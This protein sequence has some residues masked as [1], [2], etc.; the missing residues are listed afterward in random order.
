MQYIR[1]PSSIGVALLSLVLAGFLVACGGGQSTDAMLA[2]A[3][4]YLAKNDYKAAAIQAKNVLQKDANSAEG[5]YLL[6]VALLGSGDGAGAEAEL[7]KALSFDYPKDKVALPLAR[8][9]LA[10]RQFKQLVDEYG[11]VQLPSTADQAALQTALATAYTARGEPAQARDALKAALAA[12]PTNAPALLAQAREKASAKD[13]D[14]ALASIESILVKSPG[15][16]EAWTLKGDVLRIGKRQLDEALAAYRKAMETK[17]DFQAAHVG[18]IQVLLAQAKVDDASTQLAA[19]KKVAPDTYQTRYLDTLIAYLRKEA[20]RALELSQQLTRMAPNNLRAL[21]L[22][23]AVELKFGSPVQ[24]ELHL[25]KVLKAAPQATV[26]RR[27]LVSTYLRSRQGAKALEALQPLLKGDAIDAETNAL[28]GQV[29]LQ[30]GDAKKAQ[31]FLALAAKQDP[32]N[33]NARANLALAHLAD[34]RD[35]LGFAELQQMSDSETAVTADV[36]LI[37]EYLRRGEFDKAL[38]AVDVIEKKQP[39]KPTAHNLRGRVLLA[40]KDQAGARASFERALALDATHL[41]SALALSAMD[42]DQKKPDQA[43]KWLDA[44]LAKDPK[45]TRALVLLAELRSRSGAKP[46]E[47]VDLFRKAIASNPADKAPQLMLVEYLLGNNDAKQAVAAAQTAA[48][49]ISDSP[50]I[51]DALGRAQQASGDMNQALVTYAKVATL[52]PLSPQ[53]L[54]RLANAQV[55]A[56]DKDGALAS[57][58]KALVIQPDMLEAQRRLMVLHLDSGNLK[59]ALVVAATVQQQRPKEAVGYLL[60]GDAASKQKNWDMAAEAYRRGLKQV[61]APELA[62]QLHTALGRADKVAERDKFAAAWLKDNPKDPLFR[63]YLADLALAKQDYALAEKVYLG[64]LQFQPANVVALNNLAWVTGKL[65][66]DGAIAYA[67]KAVAL[68]PNQAAFLD[69]LAML[70]SDKN[71]YARALE[72]GSRVVAMQPDNPLFRMN[73]AKIHIKGGKKELARKEL[74]GLAKLGDKFS[75]QAE[76]ASL[77]KSL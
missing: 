58:R 41:Q 43:R 33:S 71:D 24:A 73:L 67:E 64:V 68:A 37:N 70:W 60:E 61:N 59:D 39:G 40:K 12:D 31:T 11:D 74:D 56:K 38:K 22:G 3:R 50:E 77:L 44:V 19:L 27:L 63:L 13:F 23:G 21:Q 36:A 30:V 18:A 2:S 16:H 7:R 17:A 25:S 35:E 6:G 62:A 28:A 66:K 42:M 45:N 29:Y 5:R 32:K 46:E 8:A 4:E 34:G 53:P 9:L 55:Q 69:T 1:S 72:L 47:V 57:L 15:N 49:A 75:G 26:A 54:I 10:R 14:G 65:N 76:V 52:M 51:L 20:P 48:T